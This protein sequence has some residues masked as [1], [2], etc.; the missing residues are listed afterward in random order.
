MRV[1]KIN[2]S[3]LE[4]YNIIIISLRLKNKLKKIKFFQKIVLFTNT[5]I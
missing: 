2:K 1:Y 3:F 4:I 5:S